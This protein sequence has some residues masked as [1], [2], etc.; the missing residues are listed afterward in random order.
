MRV[1][2]GQVLGS[3]SA[4]DG[5]AHVGKVALIQENARERSRLLIKEQHE[6]VARM[7]VH[8]RILIETP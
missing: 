8:F 1:P 5:R 2:R 6:T 4:S 3:D 7:E